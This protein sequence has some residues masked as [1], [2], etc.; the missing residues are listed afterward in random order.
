[1]SK[2]TNLPTEE[3]TTDEPVD[4]TPPS[5]ADDEVEI[6]EIEGMKNEFI[7]TGSSLPGSDRAKAGEEAESG[8]LQMQLEILQREK[9][10]THERLLRK[11]A[12]LEN[13]RKRIE[14]EK[15]EFLRFSGG[16][17][18]RKLLPVVDNL[19][20][21]CAVAEEAGDA[22]LQEGL[23]LVHQEFLDILKKEGLTAIEAD[24]KKFDPNRH[25]AVL[26]EETDEF[27]SEQVIA[28]M[29]R[30][31]PAPLSLM[32]EPLKLTVKDSPSLFTMLQILFILSSAL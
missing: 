22:N 24:G 10:E 16:E 23:R 1:M 6:I 13:A 29:L 5:G 7:D 32:P 3:K 28:V 8:D 18:I 27:E 4:K 20:R 30:L 17:L 15:S 26:R 21:A 25:E 9:K 31:L 14:K 19:E 2:K 12:D 11:Q